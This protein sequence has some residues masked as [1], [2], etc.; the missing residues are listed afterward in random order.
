MKTYIPGSHTIQFF[1]FTMAALLFSCNSPADEEPGNDIEEKEAVHLLAE[2]DSTVQ[3]DGSHKV[4][5]YLRQNLALQHLNDN[6]YDHLSHIIVFINRVDVEI[7]GHIVVS[8]EID[9]ILLKATQRRGFRKT[10]LLLGLSGGND[11]YIP[12]VENETRLENYITDIKKI[13]SDYGL[14]GADI[15]W[16]HPE[17]AEQQIAA[18]VFAKKAY[19]ILKPEGLLL[20]Q[21]IIWYNIGHMQEVVEYLDYINLMV[22]DNFDSN[23]YHSPYSQF[24]TFI[25]NVVNRGIPREK[26]L[27]G[28][29]FYGY[30]AVKDRNAKKSYS[31]ASIL[32]HLNA[33]LGANSVT[34]SD[35]TVVS[36][37][38]VVKIWKKC[39]YALEKR[40]AG[41]MIWESHM[42]VSDFKS[43]E[44]LMNQVNH[45]FPINNE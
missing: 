23:N 26:I 33:T 29:P 36:F 40:L 1:L 19:E 12:L 24:V 34:R 8:P 17:T 45:V 28:L 22:Y 20:T 18:G 6:Y 37:D 16:E 5:S 4:V 35:G 11:F 14:D 25:D 30:T 21:A 10:K 32:H 39:A 44:S 15:D 7:D 31:Y 27:A 13:C 42:D 41:V 43:K 9:E 38:G 3:G 2:I